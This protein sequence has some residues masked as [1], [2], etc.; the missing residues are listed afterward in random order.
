MSRQ[1]ILKQTIDIIYKYLWNY[2][3]Q[4]WKRVQYIAKQNNN[5]HATL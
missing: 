4:G 3:L 1:E 2:L 5:L